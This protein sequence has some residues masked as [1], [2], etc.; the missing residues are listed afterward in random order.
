MCEETHI[1]QILQNLLSNAIKYMDKPEG[2]IKVGYTEDNYFWK[3]N[4]T[5]NGPGIQQ[6]YF[7]RIFKIFKTI[8]PPN[9]SESTGIGLSIVKK[10]VELNNG[11]VWVESELG[12]GSTFF[13]TLP[14]QT[15]EIPGVSAGTYN[16]EIE[17]SV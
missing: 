2:Q 5:D 1:I 4:V 16:Q 15:S 6:M 7:E 13:F 9:G 10:L 14:K 17:R 11:R 12:Q 8:S 3:F